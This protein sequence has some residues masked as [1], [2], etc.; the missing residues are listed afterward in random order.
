MR[1]D[2]RT[3]NGVDNGGGPRRSGARAEGALVVLIGAEGRGKDMLVAIAR[4]R[5]A[6]DPRHHF[7]ARL[8]TRAQAM[9]G[10]D[11]TLSRRELLELDRQRRLIASWQVGAALVGLPRDCLQHL[12]AG[13]IV[14]LAASR[15][16]LLALAAAWP[17]LCVVEVAS[18]PEGVARPGA[19]SR[20]AGML[21]EHDPV[22]VSVRRL[23]HEGSIGSAAAELLALL[24]GLAAQT[25]V[26]SHARACGRRARRNSLSPGRPAG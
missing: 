18:G 8:T 15:E 4:R 20:A 7:P 13:S 12:E 6:G 1:Q 2:Q 14:T 25:M 5:F 22:G 3:G 24:E 16:A 19:A 10:G 17:R 23:R 26:R 21:G 9:V 11:A